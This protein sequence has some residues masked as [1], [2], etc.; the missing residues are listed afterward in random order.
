MEVSTKKLA[1]Y[2]EKTQLL[3]RLVFMLLFNNYVF[4]KFHVVKGNIPLIFYKVFITVYLLLLFFLLVEVYTTY[5]MPFDNPTFYYIMLSI[6]VFPVFYIWF[7]GVKALE[8]LIQLDHTIIDDTVNSLRKHGSLIL[9][10]WI[11]FSCLF[12]SWR[13]GLF[14]T[15]ILTTLDHPWHYYDFWYY[16]N[17][18]LPEFKNVIG[19]TP[20]FYA[21]YPSH[22]YPP[23]MNLIRV[24]T[25]IITG[26]LIPLTTVYKISLALTFIVTPI[27]AY[28]LIRKLGFDKE[29]CVIVGLF[30]TIP[31]FRSIEMIYWGMTPIIFA[32]GLSPLV[33]AFFHDYATKKRLQSLLSASIVFGLIMFTHPLVAIAVCIGLVIYLITMEYGHWLKNIVALTTIGLTS[34]LLALFWVLPMFNLYT[35]YW[36]ASLSIFPYFIVKTFMG[37]VNYHLVLFFGVPLVL[38]FFIFRGYVDFFR[39]SVSKQG[40]KFLLIYPVVIYVLAY[41]GATDFSPVQDLQ[42]LHL[43]QYLGLYLVIVAGV[44]V[45]KMLASKS[46]LCYFALFALFSTAVIPHS[47]VTQMSLEGNILSTKLP[48]AVYGVFNWLGEN[49]NSGTRVLLEDIGDVYYVEIPWGHGLGTAL[50]PVYVGEEVKYVGG[51]QPFGHNFRENEIASTR[52]TVLFSVAVENLSYDEFIQRVNDFNIKYLIVW[53]NESKKFLNGLDDIALIETIDWFSIYRYEHAKESFIVRTHGDVSA[54]VTDFGA[55]EIKLQVKANE[56][57]KVTVSTTFFPNWKAYAG[58]ERLSVEKKDIFPEITV[59]RKKEAYQVLLVFEESRLEW[60]SKWLSV[61]SWIV[62]VPTIL[63]MRWRGL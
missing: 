32:T 2:L 33:F 18:L 12:F 13:F 39:G 61:I 15:G 40:F 46:V 59:P 19:W 34:S 58:E 8:Y 63:F 22:F 6:T 11:V 21:G 38:W 26:G 3:Y 9:A 60:F 20:Y 4:M 49:G 47:A 17:T 51:Y 5:T 37:F 35:G 29:S 52:G 43:M 53:S 16:W 44:M 30:T 36:T 50:A 25:A 1:Y 54:E 41:W 48:D 42:L 45:R 14:S 23:G 27:S 28:T 57:G 62:V 10:S 7:I 31:T 56:T 55:R 24:A